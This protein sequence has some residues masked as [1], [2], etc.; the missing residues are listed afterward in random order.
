[1]RALVALLSLAPERI[2]VR[3]TDEH[4]AVKCIRLLTLPLSSTEE[5]RKPVRIALLRSGYRFLISNSKR[6]PFYRR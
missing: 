4:A 5:E 6:F 3:V 2:K 1:M